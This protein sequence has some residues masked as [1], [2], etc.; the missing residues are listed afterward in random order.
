[1]RCNNKCSKAMKEKIKNKNNNKT[2]MLK[3]KK[4]NEER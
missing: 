2:T 3:E 4:D 1:M